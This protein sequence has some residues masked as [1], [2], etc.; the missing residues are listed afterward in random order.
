MMKINITDLEN[1]ENKIINIEFSEIF[2][3]FNK[4]K[5][6]KA[7]LEIKELGSIIKITGEINALLNLTCDM[8][9][10]EFTKEMNI[11]IE[12]FF[13]KYTLN[14]TGASEFEIKQDG[15]IEDL[16]G[17][18]EIDITDLI[19]QSVILNI[20]NKLVCDINCNGNEKVNEYLNNKPIDPRLEIFKNIKIEKE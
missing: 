14:E 15:F 17:S 7:N 10:K 16:N 9:L 5:P 3:E 12:E 20:P 18:N 13:T 6:V 4:E 11:N 8:C 1:T 19:Y 2:E